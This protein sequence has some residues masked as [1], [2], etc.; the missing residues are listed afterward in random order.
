MATPRPGR[1]RRR[2]AGSVAPP[3]TG[4]SSAATRRSTGVARGRAAGRSRRCSGPSRPAATSSPR[5][6]SRTARST[7]ARST[8]L[9]ALDLATG[10][11][12]LEVQGRRRD[13]VLA[14]GARRRRLLRRRG[15]HLPRRRRRDRRARVALRDRGRHHLRRQLLTATAWSSAPTTT[16]STPC[17]A[18]TARCCGR[19]R[20]RATST[21]RRR[22]PASSPPSSGCDGYPVRWSAL[23]DGTV[24]TQ[25]RARRLR[26]GRAPRSSATWPSSAPSRT[27]CWRSISTRGAVRWRY[28]HPVRKFPFYSSPAVHDGLV[29]IG[30]RD[31]IVHALDAATGKER[32][33]YA[34]GVAHRLLAGHRRR[35]GFLATTG[36]EVLA[37]DLASGKRVWRCESGSSF[38]A[39]PAVGAG[40]L[41]I[42]SLDGTVYCFGAGAGKPAASAEHRDPGRRH[43]ARR[44]RHLTPRSAGDAGRQR[45]RLQLPA[46]LVLE[47]RRRSRR[48]NDALAAPPRPGA[49][50][51]PL[52]AHPVLP[53]A[54]QVLLLPRLHRQERRATSTPTSTPWRARSSCYA[55]LPAVA[56]R[57]LRFVYFGG[58]T[59]S[60]LSAA[61]LAGL[62]DAP[63]GG[64]ALGRRRGGHLRVR[65][66]HAHRSRSW[67]RSAA[68]ASPG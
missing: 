65:A 5:P 19:S 42:S 34:A 45:L 48:P 8:A 12:A 10:Q 49:A 31:K 40:K 51:R 66:G 50:A 9:Y 41:V 63:A 39:S 16:R 28:E 26:P 46:V 47:R 60:Y 62:V 11:A 53:Q 24:A 64:D 2:L 32:W 35:R 3:A 18:T 43:D 44:A 20:P 17:G 13:Q 29:V 4:R 30:G 15:G 37:L 58:G 22:S 59:P 67:R 57:P 25:G 14:L 6:R 21:A 7:S 68:S 54:L 27:R 1:H 36:G 23:E 52:P 55:E 33:T 61:Q 38:A 56:G